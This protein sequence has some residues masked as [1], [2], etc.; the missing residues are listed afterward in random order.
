MKAVILDPKV[1][2]PLLDEL[3]L[4][5]FLTNEKFAVEVEMAIQRGILRVEPPLT[6][7]G[8]AQLIWQSKDGF[9]QFV[10]SIYRRF[11]Y[12]V[13][14]WLQDNGFEVLR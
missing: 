9:N 2:I 12:H 6:P 4:E 1:G 11:N 14:R 8:G 10:D 13:V 7:G 5:K 3:T